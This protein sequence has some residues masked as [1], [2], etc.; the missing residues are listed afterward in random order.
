MLSALSSIKARRGATFSPISMLKVVSAI[1][2]SEIF[3]LQKFSF[4]GIHRRFEELLGIHLSQALVSLNGKP[5]TTEFTNFWGEL[6]N[7]VKLDGV[8]LVA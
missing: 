3:D 4:F 8:L 6:Q 1:A 5:A 2:A 7:R